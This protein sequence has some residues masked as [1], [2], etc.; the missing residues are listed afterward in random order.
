MKKE[1]VE[2]EKVLIEVPKDLMGVLR[3]LKY[4]GHTKRR[5]FIDAVKS[6]ISVELNDAHYEK[7]DRIYAQYP[8]LH[9]AIT[10]Y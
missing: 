7:M 4:F 10:T 6:R 5:F 2:T 1:A 9:E 8:W 3:A